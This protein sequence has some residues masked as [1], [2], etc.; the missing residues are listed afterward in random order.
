MNQNPDDQ[1]QVNTET[2]GD[3]IDHL[4]HAGLQQ[5]QDREIRQDRAALAEIDAAL[6]SPKLDGFKRLQRLK[7]MLWAYGASLVEGVRR[8]EFTPL[9]MDK[10]QRLAELMAQFTE[11]ERAARMEYATHVASQLPFELVLETQPPVLDV[12]TRRRD[13]NDTHALTRQDLDAFL[14][15]LRVLEHETHHAAPAVLISEVRTELKKVTST[16]VAIEDRVSRTTVD[17]PVHGV[18]KL[19]KVNTIGGVVQP[20]KD[21]VAPNSD[22]TAT[23]I[24]RFRISARQV[25]MP[26]MR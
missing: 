5:I 3:R 13:T 25:T 21:I 4:I 14:E 26:N 19:L 20:G 11:S 23:T 18:I 1:T 17:S 24:S 7:K 15:R 22:I 9:F 6:A 10:A 16:S 2:D 8:T 12:T